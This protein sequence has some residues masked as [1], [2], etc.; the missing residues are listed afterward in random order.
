MEKIFLKYLKRIILQFKYNKCKIKTP[1]INKYVNIKD[2]CEIYQNVQIDDNCSLGNYVLINQ[3]TRIYSYT[4]IGNFVSIGPNVIIAPTEH[5]IDLFTTHP[6]AYEHNE[7]KIENNQSNKITTIGNDVWICA[8][9]IVKKGVKINDGAIIA[10]GAVVT[11]D[12][13]PYAIVGGVPAKIIK[14][15]FDSKTIKY[16]ISTQWWNKNIKEIKNDINL[17]KIGQNNGS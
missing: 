5:P 11:K 16:L 2:N 1:F 9:A 13:P 10:A 15:R 4:C 6:I 17:K 14:Y 3:N 7:R 12:V 8:G